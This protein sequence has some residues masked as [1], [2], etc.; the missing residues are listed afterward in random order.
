MYDVLIIGA[1]A[2]GIG[3]ALTLQAAG[4]ENFLVLEAGQVGQSF[5]SWPTDT[6][7]I[8]PSFTTNGFGM[9]DLNALNPTSSPAYTFGKEHLSGADYA[10]YL[11]I[12][13]DHYNLPVLTQTPVTKLT[14]KKDH[15]EIETD[16]TNYQAVYLIL[17]VG[18]FNFPNFEA[19][20]GGKEFGRHYS[21]IIAWSDLEGE[22]FTIIGGNE[23]AIDA[24]THLLNL[25]KK[26]DI[27]AHSTGIKA[28]SPDPSIHLSAISNQKFF[29]ALDQVKP[30]QFHLYEG[31]R[32]LAIKEDGEGYYLL[33]QEGHIYQSSTQPIL[34]TGFHNGALSLARDYFEINDH[35]ELQLNAYDESTKA[36]NLFLVGPSVRNCS[37]IFC[38]IYKFRQRFLVVAEE[39]LKR[40]GRTLDSALKQAYQAEA[41]YLAD[42]DTCQVTCDC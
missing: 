17:A 21:Q 29:D 37:V 7:F 42:L 10:K 27:F 30:E 22:Q 28:S 38:Y 40:Q 23:S 13:V 15:Y 35:G 14:K 33:D 36:N 9:P 34:A 26:V 32:I 3:M 12:L 8:T 2:A 24:A 20:L 31:S 1:G 4:V 16:Q 6:R 25:G 18:E 5:R 19:V 39:I 41:F 11:E